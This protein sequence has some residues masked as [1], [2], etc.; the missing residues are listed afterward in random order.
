MIKKIYWGAAFPTEDSMHFEPS[1]QLL[2]EWVCTGK[3][4]GVNAVPGDATACNGITAGGAAAATP[5]EEHA[6]NTAAEA[7]PDGGAAPA[8]VD[9]A[10]PVVPDAA[11]VAVADESSFPSC[12]EYLASLD[13]AELLVAG[14][15]EQAVPEA[16]AASANA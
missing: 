13:A 10:A 16:A 8:A 11:E 9:P 4:E 2:I 12:D 14:G 7:S 1:K 5:A 3:I 15:E 6:E